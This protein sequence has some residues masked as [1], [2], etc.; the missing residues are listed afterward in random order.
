E[1]PPDP[2]TVPIGAPVWNTRTYVLDH[3][4]RPVAPGAV[5]ELYLSGVQLARGYLGQAPLT[6]ERFVAD[7]F[8]TGER[9]YRT[10]DLA[11]WQLGD[12]RRGVLEYLGRTDF[13]V[14][15]RGLRI[16]LGEI[17]AALLDDER[18]ARAVCIAH[19]TPAGDQLAAYVVVR[20]DE[21]LDTAELRARLAR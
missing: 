7:P 3:A 13:Q 12:T 20:G 10:G 2:V 18:I 1:C 5:G 15:I 6:A 11:R 21:E 14:K 17:E 16:E 8:H 9:M 4:L 19:A